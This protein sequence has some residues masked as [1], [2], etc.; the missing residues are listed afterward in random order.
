MSCCSPKTRMVLASF[1]GVLG[2][3]LII[4]VLAWLVVLRNPSE[5]D[6][7]R[8]A[9]RRQTRLELDSQARAEM[10]KFAIDPSKSDLARLSV[11]RAVEVL[12]NEWKEDSA[13]GRAALLQ[14]L[15]SSKEVPS[16][17]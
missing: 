13:A 5:V 17:E 8:A 2:S 1:V 10:Q 6:A 16:F 12:V 15:E 9:L 4:G 7:E 14:R 3:F 11:D